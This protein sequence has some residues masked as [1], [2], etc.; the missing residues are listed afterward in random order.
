MLPGN[1][2]GGIGQQRDGLSI[3]NTIQRMIQ[4]FLPFVIMHYLGKRSFE[5]AKVY[6]QRKEIDPSQLA[7]PSELEQEWSFLLDET[8]YD[9]IDDGRVHPAG[10]PSI[11]PET[12]DGHH[13]KQSPEE[14]HQQ[15]QQ[16]LHGNTMTTK[17]RRVAT[18]ADVAKLQ[19]IKYVDADDDSISIS[20]AMNGRD[21]KK[22]KLMTK[23]KSG[24]QKKLQKNRRE[25]DESR[26]DD[27]EDDE[28][29]GVNFP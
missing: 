17:V 24:E 27:N 14:S 7:M 26:I 13:M 15:L 12:I 28:K 18:A 5:D 21:S 25:S 2:E 6:S 11:S 1:S 22:S 3:R 19:V 9:V 20:D 4:I 10:I 23:E 16:R 8:N 29:Q